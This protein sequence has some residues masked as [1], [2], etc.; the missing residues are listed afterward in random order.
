MMR[1]KNL[2]QIFITGNA[3]SIINLNYKA[4]G[5]KNL[6]NKMSKWLSSLEPESRTII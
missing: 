5:G 3:M 2:T 6:H 1:S 4:L